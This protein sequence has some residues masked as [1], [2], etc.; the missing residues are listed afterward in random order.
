V[1]TH[2]AHII[3]AAKSTSLRADQVIA[4]T[5]KIQSAKS[6]AEAARSLVSSTHCA[7][8]SLRK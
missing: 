2:T 6:A 3:E 5:K 4:L 1:K 8:S 7:T